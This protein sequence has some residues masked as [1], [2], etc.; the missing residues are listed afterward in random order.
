MFIGYYIPIFYLFQGVT[1]NER[2]PWNTT[3]RDPKKSS[4]PKTFR[5]TS[6]LNIEDVSRQSYWQIV[7]GKDY[8]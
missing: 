7:F 6:L 4:I 1:Q 2:G 8:A 3:F 5:T